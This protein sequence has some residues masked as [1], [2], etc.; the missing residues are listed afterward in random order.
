MDGQHSSIIG[1]VEG[2]LVRRHGTVAFHAKATYQSYWTYIEAVCS[3]KS[4]STCNIHG[5]SILST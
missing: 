3:A 1:D 5:A 2:I 4:N